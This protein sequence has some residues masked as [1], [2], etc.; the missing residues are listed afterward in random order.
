MAENKQNA[1]LWAIGGVLI[2]L[3]VIY[4]SVAG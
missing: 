1:L 2:I 3:G 4:F